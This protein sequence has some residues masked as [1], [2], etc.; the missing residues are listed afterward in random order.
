MPKTEPTKLDRRASGRCR[1]E[2]ACDGR[3]ILCLR[4]ESVPSCSE[5]MA[6]VDLVTTCSR[7]NSRFEWNSGQSMPDCPRCGFNPNA[8]FKRADVAELIGMLASPD[9]FVSSGA[10]EELGN[11]GDNDA[12]EPLIAAL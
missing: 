10:A 8:K 1:I 2:L 4:C 7:C 9:R 12:V 3:Q 11:R 6:M 5:R